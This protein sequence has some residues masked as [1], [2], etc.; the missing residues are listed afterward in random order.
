[1]NL[2]R[3]VMKVVSL[4][5][6]AEI[7]MASLFS[8]GTV[9][10]D[11]NQ[12]AS[13]PVNVEAAQGGTALAANF[14]ISTAAFP[15]AY[16]E[17][18][19]TVTVD[20]YG[21]QAPY[22]FTAAGLPA[23][24]SMAADTGIVTGTPAAGQKGEYTIDV[25][26]QDSAPVPATTQSQVTLQVYGKRS[27]PVADKL[28]VEMIGHYAVGTSNKD[29]GVAEIVKYNKDN[30]KLY[31]VNGSTQ[32]ASLEIVSLHADGSLVKDKQI[33]VEALAETGS[34]QY[35][36]LTSV[37]INNKTKKVV[38][39]VQELDHTKP[40]KV[41]VLDYEGSLITSYDT[42]I[43]PDMVKYTSD[44]RYI[45]TADE[46]E[47]RTETAPDPEGS[48][49]IID[50]TS[51]EVSQL[52]FDDPSII[53][54]TVHI[55]G[56]VE[57]DGKI[58]TSGPKT[59]AIH[60]LEPEYI[61]LSEDEQ[62]AYVA[63]QEN[64][65]MAVVD[66]ASK[67]ITSVRGL[68]YKDFNQPGNELDLLKDGQI[69]FENVPFYGMYMPDGIATYSVNGQQYILSANE[70]DA[71]G[72]DDRSNESDVGKLKSGL[73]PSSA[74]AQF[75]ADKGSTYDKV[76]VASDMGNDGLYM[77]GARSFS[78]WNA[79]HMSP[80]YDSGSDFEKITAERL[81]NYFN[82]SNDKIDLDSRSSK[83]GPEPE[84]VTVGKV[85]QKTLAFVGLERIGGVMTYDVSDP[86]APTFLNYIN[87]RDFTAGITSD[88]G[89]EGLDFISAFD[90]PTGRPLLLVANEVSGTVALLEL[91]VSRISLD[92][93]SLTLAAGGAKAQLQATVEPTQGGSTELVWSSTDEAVATVD[94]NGLV[95]PLSVGE[96]VITVLSKDGYG[97]AEVPVR[98]TD[99]SAVDE[100][101]KLTVMHTNDTHAHLSEVARRATLVEQVRSEGGNNLLLDAG[102]VFSGDL[103]FTKW[104]GL[105]DLAFMNYMGYDA[106]TFGNHE[107]DQ[108]T[109]A[110]ADFVSKA[111][112]PLVSANV[113][114]SRDIN[115]SHLLKNPALIDTR[116]PKTTV[117]SGVYPYVTLLVD[118]QEVG[119][120]GLTTEDTAET[121]SPGKDVIFKDAV[122][123][124]QATV[125]A[126]EK[127]GLNKIIAL[128]HLG[129]AR[130]Q[131][132]AKAVEG[133]D[134]I[135]GGHTHTTL[136][137]PEVVIDNDHQTPTVIVQANE[138]GKF[139]GRVDLQFDNNGVVLVGEGELGGKLI[140]VDNT[141]AEDTQAKDMLDPYKAELEELMKQVVGIA[142]VVLDGNRENVRSKETNLG[143]LI[144]DGM[145]AKAKE[146]KNADVALMNGGG[147]RAAIDEGE[148]TMGELR[149]VMP[150]GNT[151]FVLDVTGQQLKD[152]LE[153][154]IS[155]AKLTDLPGK[156]PQIAGMKFK[157]DPT[158]PAGNKV[159]DVQIM[160]NGSYK[161]LVLSETYRMATNSFV[162]K[163]GD[164]YKSFADA[165]AEGKYNE[166]LG[167]PDYEIFMEYVTKLGGTVS[168]KVE[169]R[170]IEQKKPA[171]PGDGGSTP[172]PGTGSGGS[173]GGGSVTPPTTGPTSP[174]TGGNSAANVLTGDDLK[175]DVS[176][177]STA[178]ITVNEAAWKKA[179]AGL[180]ASGQQELVIRA[181]DLTG[182][183]EAAIPAA[184]LIQ[185]VEQ[186]E[187]AVVV[188]ET[189]LGAYRLPLAALNLDGAL[190]QTQGSS[191]LQ[192]K[193]SVS[194]IGAEMAND[195]SRKA[196]S[197]GAAPVNGTA[198]KFG[199]AVGAQGQEQEVKD[200]GKKMVSRILPL[201]AGAN[202][203][204]VTAVIYDD[205]AGIFRFV[206]AVKTTW[207]GKPAME[208]K[209]AGNGIYTL[210]QFKKTFTDLDGHW[211]K[212]QIESMASKLLVN[213]V[214]ANA[215]AP[216]REITRAEFTAML[217]RA[218]G[219]SPVIE[220]GKFKDVRDDSAYAGEIGAASLYGI[221]EGG[222]GGAFSPNASMTR[223][224]MA[225]MLTRAME[226]V[227]PSA[228]VGKGTDAVDRFKDQASIP[229]W[230]AANIGRLADQGIV[231][232]DHRGNYGALDSVT[233]AQAALVLNRAL[234]QLQWMD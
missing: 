165:I 164:G 233:R 187:Q 143:N 174:S 219:L 27:E 5:M 26:A 131:E 20:V 89:P 226:A 182:A 15:D 32:P 41:L 176:S 71:T 196:A 153:N 38:V 13:Q 67:S 189:A 216:G 140:P 39:A 1:M 223:A 85:G 146:L 204:S 115:I 47:P 74:A 66:I 99:G 45:L 23:G 228:P 84:Y 123:S 42:G 116:Q 25:T 144:A 224:E 69:K 163:G 120:F 218:M 4:W 7:T 77:Y 63:L 191:S 112:F 183:A 107:F 10:A 136:N 130:D 173:G 21:G 134:L 62:T 129:Y 95:T 214:N 72:W 54:D 16:E 37:D 122:T 156:F 102:D 44:G 147:I 98:V 96:A 231:Q 46:G 114:L 175:I 22:T 17:E 155:G 213:G 150:F 139:L 86:S 125:E 188:V 79:D 94:Q 119:V 104:F 103:Y 170:I 195:M 108:G 29:G 59:S 101:W 167:Y 149:T 3:N 80:V 171:N 201:P 157:W 225:V 217:V 141:V 127:D 76:E 230:A 197:M 58:I 186:N 117:N 121:S 181:S 169:G 126:M 24:L 210:L 68:G 87:T 90:S 227:S 128:S 93:S 234:V 212:E 232:G 6:A 198:V 48:I 65:A 151:L 206:P 166:D 12:A 154:G 19:Y 222:N 53:D 81:P 105:A 190:K 159:F 138:W 61:A 88:S 97:A 2:K 161:P 43:Q 160:K 28:A 91:K 158:A 36:D 168:P 200:F 207:N 92:K 40:G 185:A 50:T 184:W 55:R 193:V 148:I 14:G 49:T 229:A 113:D 64:N 70:G 179:V 215:Y 51:N 208:M 172:E 205:A 199:V 8:A 106:M 82:A 145:L 180:S 202:S 133:I 78:I 162:A 194:P 109:Q 73:N 221:I 124:A 56:T 30:G 111:Q 60:D 177:G 34:F 178:Q 203:D 135:V 35:G 209:H 9:L 18:P 33:N 31:L 110:L 52:K 83:K 100:P 142:A 132:L 211:A 137:A 152:G 75:L 11:T 118:G 57:T 220:S 192:V